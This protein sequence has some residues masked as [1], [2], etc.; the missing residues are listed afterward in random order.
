MDLFVALARREKLPVKAQ[1]LNAQILDTRLGNAVRVLNAMGARRVEFTIAPA[2][3]EQF[4][5]VYLDL[6]LLDQ[7][8]DNLFDNAEKYGTPGSEATISYGETHK[9]KYFFI[10]VASRGLPVSPQRAQTLA[11]RGQRS[12]QAI[13]SG[14]G[15]HG[16]GL[17]I[18]KRIME[19]QDGWLEILPTDNRGITD[20]RLLFPTGAKRS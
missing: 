1:A 2:G 14:Q 3:L 10:S 18:V 12:D 16:L 5:L 11:E 7:M 13:R 20:F 8:L 19:A 4:P 9:G 6:D 17:Y 15:G